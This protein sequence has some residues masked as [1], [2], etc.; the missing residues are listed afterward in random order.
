MQINLAICEALTAANVPPEKARA[1]ADAFDEAIDRRYELNARPLATRGDLA[2]TRG[3]LQ[4]DI[5]GA[6]ADIIKWCMGA[7]FGSAGMAMAI[8]KLLS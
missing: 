8:V 1:V 5:A 3:V 4:K 7:I 2:E 6:K